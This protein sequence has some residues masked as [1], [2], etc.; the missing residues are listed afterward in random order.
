MLSRSRHFQT[1]LRMLRGNITGSEGDIM[2]TSFKWN[3]PIHQIAEEATGGRRTLLFMAS[4]ARRLMEPYVPAR[5]MQL[6]SAV[7]VYV[8]DGEG[9][10]HYLSA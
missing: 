3:K 9:I 1:I 10:V 6:S 2:A 8:E 4:E 5:G 7:H